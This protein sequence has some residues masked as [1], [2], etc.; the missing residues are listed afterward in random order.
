MLVTSHAPAAAAAAVCLIVHLNVAGAAAQSVTLHG[1]AAGM[2]SLAGTMQRLQ[3]TD[4]S[5]CSV[6]LSVLSHQAALHLAHSIQRCMP[7]PTR[8]HGSSM[9]CAYCEYQ[10]CEISADIYEY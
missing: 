3:A 1:R 7:P 2:S 5:S 6:S 9:V 4:A 8:D 10:K